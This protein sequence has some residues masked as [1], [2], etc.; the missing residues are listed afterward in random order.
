MVHK[1]SRDSVGYLSSH[2]ASRPTQVG[3]KSRVAGEGRV[4]SRV[5]LGENLGEDA[6]GCSRGGPRTVAAPRSGR[7][8][9][10]PEGARHRPV[11]RVPAF[12][13]FSPSRAAC[14]THGA[15]DS[16]PVSARRRRQDLRRGGVQLCERSNAR[17]FAREEGTR[18]AAGRVPVSRH[19]RTLKKT[20]RVATRDF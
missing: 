15:A 1:A 8:G 10:V 11:S 2:F 9:R 18:R 7:R 6:R 14:S 17:E 12:A 13:R 20:P 3:G 16:R 5:T 19:N 4:L